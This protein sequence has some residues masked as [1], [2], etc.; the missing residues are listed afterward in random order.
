MKKSGAW[1]SRASG[2]NSPTSSANFRSIARAF[3][4]Q[5]EAEADQEEYLPHWQREGVRWERGWAPGE[6]WEG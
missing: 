4:T 2:C 3:A 6:E 5:A 1:V